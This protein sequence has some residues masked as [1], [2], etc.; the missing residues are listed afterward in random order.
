[1]IKQYEPSPTGGAI[2]LNNK[3]VGHVTVTGDILIMPCPKGDQLFELHS[4]FGPIPLKMDGTEALRA[5]G[6]FYKLYERWRSGG[7]W[8][9]GNR[10]VL[11]LE[12]K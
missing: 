9:D 1:M 12:A 2:M 8:V 3:I 4:Y 11:Q 7:Q 10:C 5:K 6:Q